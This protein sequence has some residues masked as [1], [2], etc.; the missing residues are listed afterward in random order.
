LACTSAL[1]GARAALA[2]GLDGAKAFVTEIA[3]LA[4]VAPR[5]AADIAMQFLGAA[6]AAWFF[7][8]PPGGSLENPARRA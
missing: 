6:P 7:R 1:F 4:R 8:Y 3:Y 2:V 5:V